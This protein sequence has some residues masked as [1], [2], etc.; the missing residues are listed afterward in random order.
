MMRFVILFLPWLELFTLIELGIQTSALIAIA[1]VFTTLLFGL[2]VVQRQGRGIFERFTQA[3]DGKFFGPE[4]L[5]DD[6]A[7]GFA[8]LLLMIPGMITDV[9][10]LVVMAG[11]LRRRLLRALSSSKSEAHVPERAARSHETVEGVFRRVDDHSDT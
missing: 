10:A 5:R 3:R 1:Y 7:I 9:V 6:M 4:L 11:P 2:A 8:G